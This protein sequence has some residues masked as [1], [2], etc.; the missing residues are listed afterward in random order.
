MNVEPPY[1]PLQVTQHPAARLIAYG[2]EM[3]SNSELLATILRTG[4]S[5]EGALHLANRVLSHFNGLDGLAQA[6]AHELQAVDGLSP[7]KIAQ[8]AATIELCRRVCD[9]HER[10]RQI[11]LTAEDAAN[12]IADMALLDQ[13][14]V[15]VILLDSSRQVVVAPTLYIGTLTA[16]VLRISEVFREAITRNCAALILAHNHPSGDPTPSPQDIELTQALATAG[17]LLEIEF[18]DHL[19]IARGRWV[20]LREQGF[21]R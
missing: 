5:T 1:I 21:L 11:I 13:E 19:I 3:L 15:R 7:D 2:S 14:H 4:T 10:E 17:Q 8:I 6:S 20:S 16:S 9:P 12:F 18:V